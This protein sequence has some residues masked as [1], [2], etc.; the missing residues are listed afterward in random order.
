MKDILT[1]AQFHLLF[2]NVSLEDSN[3]TQPKDI[4]LSLRL[5]QYK[6]PDNLGVIQ[7]E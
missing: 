1:K 5:G 3:Q 7:D 2:T 6:F 4:Y